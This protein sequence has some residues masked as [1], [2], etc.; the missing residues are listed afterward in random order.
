MV[1]AVYF[2]YDKSCNLL[3]E[4]DSTGK[5]LREKAC[6]YGQRVALSWPTREESST[7]DDW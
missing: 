4:Y 7:D 6:S 2:L 5:V 3:G 1:S